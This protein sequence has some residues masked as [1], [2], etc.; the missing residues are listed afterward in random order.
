MRRR[1]VHAIWAVHGRMWARPS[2]SS[3]D[4]PAAPTPLEAP[5]SPANLFRMLLLTLACGPVR[6]PP[7]PFATGN[8]VLHVACLMSRVVCDT[9]PHTMMRCGESDCAIYVGTHDG[10]TARKVA[11]ATAAN[12]DNATLGSLPR[13]C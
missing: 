1:H 13:M 11:R 5:G 12:S 3:V 2:S 4:D 7:S 10:H 8:G 9:L 6:L